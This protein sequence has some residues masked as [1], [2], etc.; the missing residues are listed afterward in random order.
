MFIL[1]FSKVYLVLFAF[2]FLLLSCNKGETPLP[3]LSV[4]EELENLQNVK[5]KITTNYDIDSDGVSIFEKQEKR[6]YNI[7]GILTGIESRYDSTK[8]FDTILILKNIEIKGE[9]KIIDYFDFQNNKNSNKI[10]RINQ[11]GKIEDNIITESK[12]VV[13]IEKFIYDSNFCKS[14]RILSFGNNYK[15]IVEKKYSSD[16]IIE[17][18]K[19]SNKKGKHYQYKYYPNDSGQKN[20]CY[21]YLDNENKI[22]KTEFLEFDSKNNPISKITY[23]NDTLVWLRIFEYNYY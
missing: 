6:T 13:F 15:A 23:I 7:D 22:L 2:I 12:K 16:G 20:K 21:K 8:N 14:M 11:Y 9:Q 19:I 18:I 1:T 5:V 4:E 17:S 3:C 10:L